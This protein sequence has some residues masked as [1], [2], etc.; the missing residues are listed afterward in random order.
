MRCGTGS[1]HDHALGRSRGGLS[2]KIH[3]AADDRARPLALAVT[4]GQPGDTPALRRVPRTCPGRPRTRPAMVLA[5]RAY[6]S[7]AIRGPCAVG[8]SARSS[9]SYRTRPA[10]RCDKPLIR[11]RR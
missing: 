2:T 5:D 11:A 4:A 7:R 9:R 10:T 3:L 6:S 1:R 8:R